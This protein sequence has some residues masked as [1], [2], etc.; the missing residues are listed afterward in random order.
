[1]G[2]LANSQRQPNERGRSQDP[3]VEESPAGLGY[4]VTIIS[5]RRRRVDGHDNLR[6]GAKPLVDC[7]TS[8]LG[9]ASDD[10]PRLEWCYEQL[11]TGGPEGTA[12]L[13]SLKS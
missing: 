4:R 6:T 2:P 12:V 11:T 9:F 10:D 8:T 5:M 1:M 13:I 3:R 7:I